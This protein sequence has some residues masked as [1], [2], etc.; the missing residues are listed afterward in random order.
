MTPVR[1]AGAPDVA[2]LV[3]LRAAFAEALGGDFFRPSSTDTSWR[4]NAATVLE[5]QLA[6]G[7]MRVLV[8]DGD[9]GLVACGYGTIMQ[10][11]PGPHLPDG[12]VGYVSSVFTDPAHRRR[13]HCRAILNG[14]LAWFDERDVTRVDLHASADSDATYRSL[15][16][17]D[18][19]D[20]S[21]SRRA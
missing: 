13:G 6:A 19:P 4:H 7:T 9:D 8:V 21:L 3:R 18:H 14:L 20:P 11:I 1:P 10:V 5:R 16:F 17:V 2:D 12:R 15:G